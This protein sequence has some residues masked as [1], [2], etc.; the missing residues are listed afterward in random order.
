M[1]T[2]QKASISLLLGV[3]LFAGFAVLGYSGLFGEIELRFYNPRVAR[4][5]ASRADS[6]AEGLERWRE[7]LDERFSAVVAMDAVKRSWLPNQAAEDIAERDRAF[8]L[9]AEAT[10]G[11]LGARVLDSDGR[12]LHYSGFEGDVLR[13]ESFRTVY[14][15]WG[16]ESDRP[17]GYYSLPDGRD[18]S[19]LIDVPLDAFAFAYRFTDEFGVER[20]VAVF[21]VSRGG[22]AGHLIREGILSVGEAPAFAGESGVLAGVPA[23]GRG[24][25]PARVAEA[26]S[27]GLGAEPVPVAGSEASGDFVLFTARGDFPRAGFLAPASWFRLPGAMRLVL[28]GAV[29]VTVFLV[30]FLIL[31]LRQDPLVVVADRVKR[32][33]IGLVEEYLEREGELD[34]RRWRAELESRRAEARAALRRKLGKVPKKREAELDGLVDKGWSEI[35]AVLDAR[36]GGTDRIDARRLE[37]L[38]GKALSGGNIVVAAAPATVGAA[39]AP[40]GARAAIA[41]PVGVE[42]L[43]EVGELEEAVGTR[44]QQV[45]PE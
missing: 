27:G 22:L 10:P 43:A 32:F 14:R 8:G 42:E 36:L 37:E 1:T 38:L 4:A 6:L 13:R 39:A 15:A 31:N 20:G 5:A 26:W 16:D 21:W 25:L 11:Y 7:S 44:A 41:A 45:A 17:Y 24:E 12:R 30:A 28:L 2:G 23:F 3:I 18:S 33:Q 9:L 40:S 35:L 19:V 29:F 34:L